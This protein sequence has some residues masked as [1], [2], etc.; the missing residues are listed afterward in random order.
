MHDRITPRLYGFLADAGAAA[1]RDAARLTVPTLL[2]VAGD[3]GL[4]DARGSREL[5]AGL[6]PGVGTLH[7]YDGLYH[8]MFNEREPDRTRVLGD[9]DGLARAAAQPLGATTVRSGQAWRPARAAPSSA[10][11]STQYSLAGPSVIWRCQALASPSSAAASSA[12]NA[13][14]ATPAG[15]LSQAAQPGR[16]GSSGPA[17]C[18]ITPATPARAAAAAASCGAARAGDRGAVERPERREVVDQ[19]PVLVAR[20]AAEPWH[21]AERDRRGL[22]EPG[23][24]ARTQPVVERAE[25]RLVVGDGTAG[26]GTC[27]KT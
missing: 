18:A 20:R 3:D 5:A 9:L 24:G 23:R 4:V 13:S 6:A 22:P 1:R 7:V 15:L 17:T 11:A 10:S 21:R 8:E 19:V 2:L 27:Q 25:P 16:A 26:D 12:W 14:Y